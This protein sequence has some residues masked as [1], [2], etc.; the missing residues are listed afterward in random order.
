MVLKTIVLDVDDYLARDDLEVS[1][2]E[3]DIC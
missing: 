1:V 2:N 3:C